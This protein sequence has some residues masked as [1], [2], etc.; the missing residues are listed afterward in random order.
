MMADG[1]YMEEE[2]EKHML[3]FKETPSEVSDWG[4]TPLNPAPKTQNPACFGV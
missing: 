1:L 3:E 4:I 2:D